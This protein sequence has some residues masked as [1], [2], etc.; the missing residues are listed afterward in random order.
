MSD[1][2]FLKR[3]NL[4]SLIDALLAAGYRCIAPQ[5]R[6]GVILYDEIDQVTQLP[7]GI[8]DQQSPA[9]YQLSSSDSP[10]HFAWANG[11]QAL[12]PL[13]F[14]P[15]E[16]LWRAERGGDGKMAF[17]ATQPTVQ[18][19]A[20]IGVRSCDLAALALQ[21]QHFLAGEYVDPYY[22]T[23]R[24]NLFTVAVNCSHPAA[25]CFCASTGDG[26]MAESGYDLVMDELEEGYLLQSGS[27]AGKKIMSQ[28]PLLKASDQQH[29]NAGQQHLH[30]TQIQ[31]RTLPGRQ[32]N[33]ALFAN[34]D[35][36]R[37]DDVAER[38]L[39]CGN[40]TM[41]CPTCFC[42]A[43][44]EAPQLDGT[45]T[46]HLR[47]WDSCFTQGHSYIHGTV[48]RAETKLRYRQWLTHKL[49]SWHEQYGRSGCVGCGRC[50]SWCPAAIDLTEEATVICGEQHE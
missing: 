29:Y 10:R 49:G 30:A 28:L 40:C 18:P 44:N 27:D 6:D 39:S 23:R 14:A 1:P 36:A 22:Q 20:V 38:C 15:R 46:E 26:P 19:T 31:Q 2:Y 25:T 5:V 9:R 11:P 12:K 42:H 41:V 7:Q 48:I 33:E 16:T 8:H 37:W 13:L 21:D 43:E 24:Q 34:L 17:V 32:L 47:E 4:Q 45:A 50:I 35:H 3:T